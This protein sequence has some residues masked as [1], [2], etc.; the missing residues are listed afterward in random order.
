MILITDKYTLPVP[1]SQES[2]FVTRQA[3]ETFLKFALLRVAYIP[4]NEH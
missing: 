2:Q 3:G 1:E 4:D